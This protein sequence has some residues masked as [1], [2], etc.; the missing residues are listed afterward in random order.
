MSLPQVSA[1]GIGTDPAR[2]T[3]VIVV[4]V[5]DIPHDPSTSEELIPTELESVPVRVETTGPLVAQARNERTDVD[6]PPGEPG[7][8]EHATGT[9]PG[10]GNGSRD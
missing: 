8:Q 4:L 7:T 6:G 9:Q 5:G 2:Q 3:P 10:A 1:V